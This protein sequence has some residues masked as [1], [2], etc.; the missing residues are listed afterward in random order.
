MEQDIT[1]HLRELFNPTAI[2]I[3]GSRASGR[4]REHSDWDYILI[5]KK[6]AETPPDNR[7]DFNG[8]NIEYSSGKLPIDDIIKEFGIKLRFARVV[9]DPDDICLDLIERV[10]TTYTEPLNWTQEE[11]E[12]QRLW[13]LGRIDG[14]KDNIKRPLQFEKYAADFYNRVTNCWYWAMRDEYSKPIYMALEEIEAEDPALLELLK[15]FVSLP[16]S[17]EKVETALKIH[18]HYFSD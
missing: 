7:L 5:Y 6:D 10:R 12:G 1:N 11:R 14:M 16:A 8:Q 4:A 17:A 18:Q 9:F 3:H 15:E 13:L 2:I